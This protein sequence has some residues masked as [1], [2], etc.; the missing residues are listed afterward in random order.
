M[1]QY[2]S[3]VNSIIMVVADRNGFQ[4]VNETV[5]KLPRAHTSVEKQPA[6]H[7]NEMSK[8]MSKWHIGMNI[9]AALDANC[10]IGRSNAL[11]WHLPEEYA[12]FIRVTTQTTDPRK[13]NSVLMGRKCWE[14]IPKKFKPLKGRLNIV[15]SQT[16]APQI[17]DQM[18]VA[19][20][21]DEVFAILNDEPFKD[22]VETIW[23]VGGHDIYALGLQHPSLHKVVLTRLDK[24]FDCDVHFPTVDWAQF[25]RN[26]D[27]NGPEEMHEERGVTWHVT[28]YTRKK[29]EMNQAEEMP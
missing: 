21:L 24:A 25:E 19:K 13:R 29:G 2:N 9:I 20:Q 23:N 26:D 27:F 22:T 5:V 14:S 10:G 7:L 4:A 1:T 18:I 3:V 28:S 8:S 11:P 17:N 16:M 12:H 15:L 6:Q